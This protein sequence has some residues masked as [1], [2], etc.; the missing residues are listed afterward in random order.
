MGEGEGSSAG[1]CVE[2]GEGAMAGSGLRVGIAR[3][4]IV[5]VGAGCGKRNSGSVS[6]PH[7]ARHIRSKDNMRE[8][9]VL[10]L[11]MV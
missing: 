1:L 9:R 3:A 5:T 2:E 8:R 6:D 4:S 7:P 10:L 11:Y